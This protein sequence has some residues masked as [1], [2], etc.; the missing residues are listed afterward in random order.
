MGY[1]E[2]ME[3]SMRPVQKDVFIIVDEWWKELGVLKKQKDSGRTIR[4]E[5]INF[6]TLE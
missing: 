1:E 4:P 2:C 5:Y 3:K 6:R